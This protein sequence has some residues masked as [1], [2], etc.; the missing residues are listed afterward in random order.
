MIPDDNVFDAIFFK[1]DPGESGVPTFA[2]AEGQFKWIS[3]FGRI[4]IEFTLPDACKA[5]PVWL[6]GLRK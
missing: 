2:F 4:Y 6:F 1:A 5:F 3:F